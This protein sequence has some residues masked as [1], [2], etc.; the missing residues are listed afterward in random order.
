MR[1]GKVANLSD[2]TTGLQLALR[3]RIR[4]RA[5]LLG[6]DD[7][8]G[9]FTTQTS[10][11]VE[12]VIWY[13][14][15]D[16]GKKVLTGL[17]IDKRELAKE[18]DS[19]LSLSLTITEAIKDFPI[20][21]EALSWMND[22]APMNPDYFVNNIE[23]QIVADLFGTEPDVAEEYRISALELLANALLESDVV[24]SYSNQNRIFVPN[25]MES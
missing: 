16:V 2:A 10:R 19:A 14:L 22:I 25:R 5:D 15:R 13:A 1:G 3:G 11:V 4:L 21:S 18:V 6:F 12:D 7:R 9:I 24:K 8:E 17:S 23:E 20:F